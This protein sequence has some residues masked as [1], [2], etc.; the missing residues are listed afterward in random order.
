[1]SIDDKGT[2]RRPRSAWEP[3]LVAIAVACWVIGIAAFVWMLVL[4]TR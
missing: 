4:A 1:M 2:S 3:R